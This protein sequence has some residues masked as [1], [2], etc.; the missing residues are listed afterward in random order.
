MGVLNAHRGR[1]ASRYPTGG[2]VVTGRR[3][4]N[5]G[6]GLPVR[7][8]RG[9]SGCRRGISRSR[10][11][12]LGCHSFGHRPRGVRRQIDCVRRLRPTSARRR[13]IYRPANCFPGSLAATALA[14]LAHSGWRRDHRAGD[15]HTPGAAQLHR[16]PHRRIEPAGQYPLTFRTPRCCAATA[17]V[18]RA[19]PAAGPGADSAVVPGRLGA[20]CRAGHAHR[21]A[22]PCGPL[23]ASER[24]IARLRAARA[25]V[26]QRQAALL[27]PPSRYG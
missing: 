6:T 23:P 17:R 12:V 11:T 15:R 19:V 25:V 16:V 2:A 14:A 27:C 13:R 7:G 4:G 1:T 20:R 26:A 22:G 21:T 18:L 3:P 9:G 8:E 10:V 24:H 5:A